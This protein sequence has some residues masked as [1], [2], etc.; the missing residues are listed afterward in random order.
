MRNNARNAIKHINDVLFTVDK[1]CSH[2]RSVF[3][4]VF[5]EGERNPAFPFRMMFPSAVSGSDIEPDISRV[6]GNTEA[7]HGSQ[8]LLSV[9]CAKR[10][11]SPNIDEAMFTKLNG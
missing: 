2:T 7:C 10:H 8:P 6:T 1:L 9:C 3:K 11:T 5:I 4:R